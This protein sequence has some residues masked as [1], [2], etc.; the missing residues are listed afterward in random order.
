M[1]IKTMDCFYLSGTLFLEHINMWTSENNWYKWNYGNEPA[2]G[3]Q[4]GSLTFNTSYACGFTGVI[5]NFKEELHKAAKS[6]LDHY[7]GLKPCVFFSGGLDSELI[8][9]SYLSIGA[10]PEVYIV[11]YEKDYNLY[12]V[13]YAVTICNILGVK[14]HIVDFDLEKFYRNDA[15]CISE[16]SQIDRP[17]MLPHLKFT[18]CA[19]GLIIVGH[20]DVRW[21]R[22]DDDYSKQG[23]WLAQDFEHDIGCDKYNILHNRPAIYQWWKWSPG[24]VLSYTKLNWFQNLIADRYNGKLGVNS[25]KLLGFKEIYPDLLPRKKL[26]GFENINQLVEELEQHF[27]KKYNGLLYRQT[28]DRNL[29]QLIAEIYK[30]D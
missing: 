21:Y 15:D 26:T 22:T 13:S 28:V 16:Q 27:I 3:N 17:R 7:P 10:K 30:H 4:P 24:L 5:G 1:Q 12:D 25:T 18:E 23:T 8:L 19:D 20:S 14:Y 11:R 6:T 9:R 2:F 29:D